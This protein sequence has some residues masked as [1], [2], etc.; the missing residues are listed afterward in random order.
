[1][2]L[3]VFFGSPCGARTGILS[4]V[5]LVAFPVILFARVSDLT[6]RRICELEITYFR[7]SYV[8]CLL[9]FLGFPHRV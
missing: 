8:P 2:R 1:M 5:V 6:I 4:L 3:A 9:L 7:V